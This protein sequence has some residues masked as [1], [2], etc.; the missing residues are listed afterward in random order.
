MTTGQVNEVQY[1]F[2]QAPGGSFSFYFGNQHSGAIPASA[3]EAQVEAALE[4]MRGVGDVS[5]TF[6]NPGSTVCDPVIN[7]VRLEFI[8][9][10]GPQ[11]PLV[12]RLSALEPGGSFLVSADG[13]TELVDDLGNA[14]L[15]VKGTKENAPCSNRGRCNQ[16][17][18]QCECY[19]TNGVRYGSSDGRGNP[20]TR[21][22]CG[23]AVTPVLSCPGSP[24]CSGHGSCVSAD[25]TFRCECESGWT[26]GDCSERTCPLGGSWFD[27][28]AANN[29]AHTSLVE[30]SNRGSCDRRTGLCTC[31]PPFFGSAC[32]YGTQNH[33]Q[34]VVRSIDCASAHG[35]HVAVCTRWW[36]VVRQ[37]AARAKPWSRAADT[38]D[39]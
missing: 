8:D 18:G 22:D 4:Q 28:P 13:V 23:Y 5:V 9:A 15:S 7:M 29:L 37:W 30:C 26:G 14:Y 36:D 11:P 16:G 32:E 33:P 20:G 34:Q 19:D 31:P 17:T 35:S 39:A 6:A 1:F 24:F 21:G 38:A 3:T 10:F 25:S 2:C 27:Y 12:P